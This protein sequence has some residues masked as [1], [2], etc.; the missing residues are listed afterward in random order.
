M[1]SAIATLMVDSVATSLYTRK[2]NSGFVIPNGGG[3]EGDQEMV[4]FHSHGHSHGSFTKGQAQGSQLLRYRVIAMVSFH[5]SFVKT[6]YNCLS[7]M[8]GKFS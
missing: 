2:N 5:F 7:I 3:A 8:L 4:D 6:G 1:I